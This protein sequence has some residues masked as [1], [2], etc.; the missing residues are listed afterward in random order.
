MRALVLAPYS[1]HIVISLL[2][3]SIFGHFPKQGGPIWTPKYNNL[4]YWD[5]QY[6][7]PIILGNT[8]LFGKLVEGVSES[9]S[10]NGFEVSVSSTWLVGI[11]FWRKAAYRVLAE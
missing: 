1:P 7:V 9:L 10:Q 2:C 4:C 6:K 3:L 5:P 8:R 11:N